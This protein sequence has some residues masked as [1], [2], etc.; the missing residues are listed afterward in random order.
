FIDVP[1]SAATGIVEN[2]DADV[3]IRELPGKVFRGKVV[4]TA[5]AIDPA[6]RTLRT[7]LFLPNLSG[8]LLPGMYV[9][10]KLTVGREHPGV[11]IPARTL[12]LRKEG[13]QVVVVTPDRKTELRPVK[14]GRDFG[15]EI[16]VIQGLDGRELL[17][18]NPTD[19]LENGQTVRVE[20]PPRSS[21]GTKLAQ[22]EKNR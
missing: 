22:I 20:G 8:E 12:V 13:P 15:S 5:R 16:E 7:E 4:R 17:V 3:L 18:E 10:V 21:P 14:L 11:L 6:T 19:E 9:Q 2:Q 1:Q